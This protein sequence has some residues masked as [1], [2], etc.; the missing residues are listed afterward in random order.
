MADTICRFLGKQPLEY[1]MKAIR[2]IGYKTVID[3]STTPIVYDPATV[4]FLEL[5]I[6]IT[7]QNVE[8]IDAVWPYMYDYIAGILEKAGNQS[9]LLLERTV[10]GLLRVCICVADKVKPFSLTSI[11]NIQHLLTHPTNSLACRRSLIIV[12][13]CF[14]TCRMLFYRLLLNKLWPVFSTF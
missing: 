1:L 14:S 4:F 8:R 7:I 10:V 9:V 2:T 5:M 13:S 11:A 12:S 3:Q 6:S